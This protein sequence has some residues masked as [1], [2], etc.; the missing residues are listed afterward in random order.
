MYKKVFYVRYITMSFCILDTLTLMK[1]VVPRDVKKSFDDLS[2]ECADMA[3]KE[4]WDRVHSY[5]S[6]NFQDESVS[7]QHDLCDIYH[8][9]YVRY[10]KIKNG[11]M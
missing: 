9:E 6:S 3:L 10:L 11:I 5:L 4:S 7:W 2:E 1:S 8:E